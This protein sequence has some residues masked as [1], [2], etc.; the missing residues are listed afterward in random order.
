[1]SLPRTWS[2]QGE[3]FVPLRLQLLTRMIERETARLMQASFDLSVAEW[4][5][6]ALICNT[7]P[8][9][10]AEVSAAYEADPGQVSRAV[11]S[12]IK[13]QLIERESDSANRKTKKIIPT[14]RGKEVFDILRRKREAYYR[15]ILQDLSSTDLKAF[16]DML[17]RIA[18]RVDEQRGGLGN[19]AASTSGAEASSP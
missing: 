10:A 13:A 6:L 8:A 14:A 19:P 12:L 2:R 1:M 18:R 7:G 17:T 15:V 3:Y 16:D 4:R 5:V 11:A 9:S